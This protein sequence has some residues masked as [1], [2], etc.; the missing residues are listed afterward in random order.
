VSANPVF[1]PTPE[2]GHAIQRNSLPDTL[3]ESLRQRIMSGEF[4]EGDQ[5]IQDAIAKEYDVSRIPVREA[6][7]QLE[8]DG[9]VLLKMHK[10]AIVTSIPTEQIAELFELRALLECDLLSYAV[11]R[12]TPA[13]ITAAQAILDQL[14][15]SYHGTDV[16]KWAT[17]N[18]E[19]HRSLYI[20]A[21]R[22]QSMGLVR[23]INIQTDRYI[24][25]QALIAKS[26]IATD[27]HQE[28]LTLCAAGDTAAAVALM[29]RHITETGR[30]LLRVLA[31]KRAKAA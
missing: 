14:E 18:W 20:A 2:P 7:R 12:M 5:L 22:V 23:S 3:A 17:L 26:S 27:E 31:E 21:D 30:A 15:E 10:G 1:V 11:P 19:F 24:Q 13:H 6:L 25:L 8:A 28:L 29:S 16:G 4:K 9:L